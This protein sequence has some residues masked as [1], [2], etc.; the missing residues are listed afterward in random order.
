LRRRRQRGAEAALLE[1][2]LAPVVVLPPYMSITA[3]DG[4]SSDATRVLYANSPGTNSIGSASLVSCRRRDIARRGPAAAA[5]SRRSASAA[6]EAAHFPLI[7]L[8]NSNKGQ[9]TQNDLRSHHELP[10]LEL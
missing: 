1:R 6:S 3:H 4:A 10:R 7:L 2:L 8:Q 9:N 5:P